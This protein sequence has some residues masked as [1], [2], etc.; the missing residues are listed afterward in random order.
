[1]TNA[2]GQYYLK[3]KIEMLNSFHTFSFMCD[4]LDVDHRKLDNFV[5]MK[6]KQECRG[7]MYHMI[8]F[9]YVLFLKS[10]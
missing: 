4:T 3:N 10:W 8:I 5:F 9:K 6:E 1:M 2:G 7:I